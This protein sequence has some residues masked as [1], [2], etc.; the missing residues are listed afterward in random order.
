MTVRLSSYRS[1]QPGQVKRAADVRPRPAASLVRPRLQRIAISDP[2]VFP[3]VISPTELSLILPV[4]PS[5]NHQYATV[6]GRRLLS[7]V[8]RGYKGL[9]SRRILVCLSQSPHRAVL[10]GSLRDHAL[11]LSIRFYFSSPLRR[12]L[13]G[14]LKIAQDAIC[15]ALGIN[16]NRISEIYLFKHVDKSQPRIEVFLRPLAHTLQ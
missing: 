10:L 13:D 3:A 11:S 4:P 8:G 2:A 1:A 15:E 9:I 5:I 7:A 12:D 14:G 16:D 6:N